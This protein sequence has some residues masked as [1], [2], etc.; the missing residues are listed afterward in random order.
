MQRVVSNLAVVALTACAVVFA[1]GDARA[2]GWGPQV[3]AKTLDKI[4]EKMV[5]TTGMVRTR[6]RT[7]GQVNLPEYEAT[8]TMVDV[9]SGATNAVPVAK[10]VYAVAIQ[11]NASRLDYVGANNQRVIR[12]VKAGRAWNESWSADGKKLST[13]PADAA[14]AYRAQTLW[15]QPHAFMHAVAFAN[16]KRLLNGQAGETPHSIKQE[17]GKTVIEVQ[18]GNRPYK[19]TLGADGRPETIETMVTV[20]GGAQKRL[21]AR[22][23]NW[24]TGE[25]TDAGF[26]TATGEKVLDKFHSGAYWPSTIVHELDGAKVLDLTLTAGW[27]NPFQIFP[28]PELLAKA[29]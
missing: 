11:H 7:V 20:P 13:A 6:A 16:G 25:K 26:G 2:Q 28:D 19:G 1:A 24:R 9:E 3:E 10:Y 4:I 8:G 14:A 23:T 15:V 22:F 21:V 27:A 5:D 17:G 18:I 29:Q 12:V